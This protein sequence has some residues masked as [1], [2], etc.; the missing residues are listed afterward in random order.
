MKHLFTLKS[1]LFLLGVFVF[2]LPGINAQSEKYNPTDIVGFQIQVMAEKLEL[3]QEQTQKL[4][5]LNKADAAKAKTLSTEEAKKLR[6]AREAKYKTI[7]TEA[8]Y[9]QWLKERDEINDEAQFRY[10][11]SEAYAKEFAQ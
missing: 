2:S 8:Q 7:L 10:L 1:L 11:T 9:K 5:D 4:I 3:T 6:D